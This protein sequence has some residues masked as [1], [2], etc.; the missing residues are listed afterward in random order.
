MI[1]TF[2]AYTARMLALAGDDEPLGVLDG[3][4]ALLSRLIGGR[5]TAD[6]Q[7]SPGSGR[8]SV[9]EILSHLADAEIVFAYRT[10]MILASPG[11]P[12]QAFDQDAFVRSQHAATSD[13][14]E[15]LSMLTT[16]RAA[17]LRLLRRLTG[18]ELDRFGIHSERGKES[19]RHMQRMFAGHDRNHV[20]QIE[21]LL[22]A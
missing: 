11:T 14:F 3:T 21:R 1:E 7:R 12:I 9:A 8:W 2:D 22:G 15:S 19:L 13:A 10:R 18:E 16:L 20:A 5:A 17:N 6:L 4:P